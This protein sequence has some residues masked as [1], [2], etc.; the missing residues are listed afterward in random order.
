MAETGQPDTTVL[1]KRV[2]KILPTAKQPAD[3]SPIMEA[4]RNIT[5]HRHSAD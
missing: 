2:E 5:V 1:L 3:G 4:L